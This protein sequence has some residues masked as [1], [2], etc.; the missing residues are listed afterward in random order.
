MKTITLGITCGLI[1]CI[2]FYAMVGLGKL[3]GT[4]ES[5]GIGHVGGGLEYRLS[6]NVGI[7]ADGRWVYSPQLENN[8]GVLARTG[9]RVAF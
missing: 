2:I 8:G 7:F 5:A 1:A 6:P 3:Y 9:L 4:S